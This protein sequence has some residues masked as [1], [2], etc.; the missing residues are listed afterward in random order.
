MQQYVYYETN[1]TSINRLL[2]YMKDT[3][4]LLREDGVKSKAH[5][6]ILCVDNNGEYFL[7][8]KINGKN[9]EGSIGK[10]RKIV[11]MDGKTV[12]KLKIIAVIKCEDNIVKN[13]FAHEEIKLLINKNYNRAIKTYMITY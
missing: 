7:I 9:I 2:S 12:T 6:I 13:V 3:F 5:D 10:E 8:S 1:T 11:S 4:E